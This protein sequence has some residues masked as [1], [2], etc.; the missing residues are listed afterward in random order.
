MLISSPSPRILRTGC[1]SNMQE[2]EKE[3]A[4]NVSSENDAHWARFPVVEIAPMKSCRDPA[5]FFLTQALVLF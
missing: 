2:E 5:L 3:G 4:I 1:K